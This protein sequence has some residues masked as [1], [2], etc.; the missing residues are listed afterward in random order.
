MQQQLPLL[1][2]SPHHQQFASPHSHALSMSPSLGA[3]SASRQPVKIKLIRSKSST[4]RGKRKSKHYVQSSM[5]NTSH[6]AHAP[7]HG[8]GHA[9]INDSNTSTN[10]GTNNSDSTTSGKVGSQKKKKKTSSKILRKKSK[11]KKNKTRI[12]SHSSAS[13]ASTVRFRRSSRQPADLEGRKSLRGDNEHSDDLDEGGDGRLL[14]KTTNEIDNQNDT[15]SYSSHNHV[16]DAAVARREKDGDC[17]QI[18]GGEANQGHGQD[19]KAASPKV[20]HAFENSMSL[21]PTEKSGVFGNKHTSRN[22]SRSS[23]N[24][25]SASNLKLTIA[26]DGNG[27]NRISNVAAPILDVTSSTTSS[28]SEAQTLTCG[29]TNSRTDHSKASSPAKSGPSAS[30]STEVNTE[31]YTSKSFYSPQQYLEST[32]TFSGPINGSNGTDGISVFNLNEYSNSIANDNEDVN[33]EDSESL[34]E[35]LSDRIPLFSQQITCEDKLKFFNLWFFLMT[36]ANLSNIVGF[37]LFYQYEV[38]RLFPNFI[39]YQ[40]RHAFFISILMLAIS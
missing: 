10:E 25:A 9:Q 5:S 15:E 24:R 28:Q 29:Y 2:L 4:H 38:C 40:C 39:H 1:R 6:T 33:D 30:T 3:V 22:N 17:K 11:R 18:D 21:K 26:N 16:L 36:I 37:G 32:A 35:H 31:S 7:V 12:R 8:H 27:N 19:M 13:S 34:E 23:S 20:Q 14:I